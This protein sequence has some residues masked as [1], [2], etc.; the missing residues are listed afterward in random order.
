MKSG[1]KRGRGLGVD[2]RGKGI[3]MYGDGQM[4]DYWW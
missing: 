3:D 2:K 4:L 1:L